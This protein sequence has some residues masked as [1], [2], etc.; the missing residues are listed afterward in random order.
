MLPA[1]PL[2]AWLAV[3]ACT[4]TES[5]PIDPAALPFASEPL[6][7]DLSPPRLD[8]PGEPAEVSLTRELCPGCARSTIRLNTDG[9]VRVI[10]ESGA[11]REGKVPPILVDMLV[12]HARDSGHLA[13]SGHHGDAGPLVVTVVV[14]AGARVEAHDRGQAA[15]AAVRGF[16]W[17]VEAAAQ[18]ATWDPPPPDDRP[19]AL[20]RD[21]CMRPDRADAVD[22]LSPLARWPTWSAGPTPL[23]LDTRVPLPPPAVIR[24]PRFLDLREVTLA[25][26]HCHGDCPVYHARLRA[27]GRVFFEGERMVR[28]EGVRLGRV[29]PVVVE[30]LA[31][32]AVATG[33]PATA[34]GHGQKTTD[35]ARKTTSLALA[36][37]RTWTTSIGGPN[38]QVPVEID[39]FERMIDAALTMVTWDPEPPTATPPADEL[40]ASCALVV[41]EAAARCGELL[42][43][44]APYAA[45]D[46][47]F[48][49]A[50]AVLPRPDSP[51]RPDAL[52]RCE[53]LADVLPDPPS[54]AAKPTTPI[55]PHCRWPLETVRAR[56][57]HAWAAGGPSSPWCLPWLWRMA[58]VVARP[59][60][61]STCSRHADE[62]RHY[63]DDPPAPA[64][65]VPKARSPRHPAAG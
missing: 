26:T 57:V 38:N 25:R 43:G 22:L 64:K 49:D 44:L 63:L 27:D 8:P 40:A 13:A 37:V 33:F 15:P 32:Y 31:T 47:A 30:M 56:C 9:V 18:L 6:A 11:A 59:D 14:V 5:A 2:A 62:I 35:V 61:E 46:R 17:I 28:R 21:L 16:E 53:Y 58:D 23:C 24:E 48:S 34:P 19:E 41:A 7:P 3:A 65:P 52:A 20:R 29:P 4:G 51:A 42:D 36:G 60:D 50:L 39:G 45:C 54:L 12:R 1:R 10:P 55:H